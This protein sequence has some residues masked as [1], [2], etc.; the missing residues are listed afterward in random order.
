M[1][2]DM[3]MFNMA[4]D[5][6]Q[7]YKLYTMLCSWGRDEIPQYHIDEL[8]EV[9]ADAR[10]YDNV[11]RPAN[12]LDLMLHARKTKFQSLM[13]RSD[14]RIRRV[15]SA[16]AY[17]LADYLEETVEFDNIYFARRKDKYAKKWKVHDIKG[18]P[19]VKDIVLN[20][21]PS[22]ALKN[23]AIHALG[24][25]D[26][27]VLRFR[28]I[29]PPKKA[30]PEE[31]LYAPFAKAIGKPGAWK[32]SWPDVIKVHI[33]HWA[34]NDL[35]RKY[36]SNDI[37]YTRG[38]DKYFGRPEAGD[39]DSELAWMTG[40]V[41]W[42][43]FKID[44]EGFKEMRDKAIKSMSKAP[45]APRRAYEWITEG[46][47]DIVLAVLDGS[48]KKIK[49]Q[50]LS[51]AELGQPSERAK[52]V[53]EARAA[54]KE[55][56]I[57]DKL[58]LA[59]RFHASFKVIGALSGRM[60]GADKL[61][62][63]GIKRTKEVRSKFAL[64][65][66]GFNLVGGDFESF[67]MVL[68]DAA[69]EDPVM[70][71]ELMTGLSPHGS[72]GTM[73]F[74]MTYEAVMAT[75]GKEDDRYTKA[76]SG[77]FAL[78]YGGEAFTLF[79]KLGVEMETA[80]LAYQKWCSKYKVWQQK[81]K[82]IFDRFC[83]MRQPGGI[84]SKVEWHDP[85]DY[86]ESLLGFKRHFTLENKVCKALFSI[87]Q[88][89]PKEW[90]K[91]KVKVVRRDRLQ[92]ASGALQSALF[93]CA[94][95]IQAANM[96]AAANHVIQSSGAGI[97]KKMQKSIWDLQPKGVNPWLVMTMNVH[98]E[99]MVPCRPEM[100]SKVK[101]VVDNIINEYKELVPLLAIDWNSDMRTWAD[102]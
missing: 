6:F 47:D 34:F 20:F 5:A 76:K 33:N 44:V 10:L 37:V 17:K 82:E 68:A 22:M 24:E 46:A 1:A 43:G 32:K 39:V 101:E 79:T 59:G 62:P 85:D 55:I 18:K 91:V 65:D 67:E 86:V 71:Q 35:A 64:A 48:T 84:G 19:D 8:A 60:A 77:V 66:D 97:C 57:F 56:E 14:I 12:C 50:A 42:R 92:T 41:R 75:K 100:K 63:Q 102:K 83:S 40:V 96:R 31:K 72:L 2:E 13:E 26:S 99:I 98:D 58:I 73:L 94:F 15:P 78:L 54:M 7:I 88:R 53:L 11:I 38:L 36:A 45:T 95:S 30:Y 51:E 4:F 93:A 90:Q 87:A 21:Q 3:V 27:D 80:E 23:L 16:L 29:N 49:L 52:A 70:H 28:D 89:P 9:E 25:M 74:N 69:Y 61:N 81:R